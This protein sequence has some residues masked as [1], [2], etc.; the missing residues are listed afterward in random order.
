MFSAEEQ[1]HI[2]QIWN[3]LSGHEAIFGTELL[4]RLFTVYPSTKSYFPPLIPGLE[5]TQ[6][7]NHGEQILMAVGVAVDN[8]YDLRT[9]LSGLA[10]LH[11]YGLR[12]EPT[13]FHFLIHCFQV[14]L[15]S[16]L[17]SEYTAEMH[18][19]WDKFL[20]NV[21]VVLTEKYH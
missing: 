17:Q 3:Y 14:M 5:L 6:M 2:V 20:T 11:A 18:A 21:A 16:H 19:A 4:Q 8:M 15:A 9:A 7:Q 13:N 10:D 1:S 12:V